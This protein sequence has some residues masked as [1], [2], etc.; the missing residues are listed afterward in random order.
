MRAPLSWLREYVDLPDDVDRRGP[1]RTGSTA[2]GLKLEALERPGADIDGPARRRP[3]AETVDEPQKN[4]KTI[5]W[6]QVDCGPRAR[7]SAASSAART[8][9]RVG[10]LVVVSLPGRGAA[11]RLRDRRP[12]DLR[13]RLRRDD[14][15]HRASSASATTTAASSCS[16]RARRRRRA[17]RPTR[18]PARACATTSSSSRST[19]TAATRL[20]LRGIAREAAIAYDVPFRDPALRDVPAPN[21]DGYPV[22][23]RGRP[24]AARS[25]STRTVTGLRPVG[26]DPAVDAR[27]RV[28]LAGMR[29]ISLAV[30]VTNYV[31]LEL[32]QP[33]HGYDARPAGRPDRRAPGRRE[34]ETLTTLDDVDAHAVR[35][36]PADHRRQRPDRHR[37]RH[38]RRDHRAVGETTATWSS[39]PRTSSRPTIFRTARRHKLPSEASKRFE[40][41]VD[42]LLPAVRRRPGRRT[43]SSS[44]AAARVDRRRHLR[45]QRR[46]DQPSITADVD[47]P[48]RV[49]GM[50]IDADDHRRAPAHASAARST[51]DGDGAL[52]RR[53]RRP[54]GPT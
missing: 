2:L 34:G 54:G 5:N 3:G 37:R 31:M 43:C 20:S 38:G 48:A 4:G 33:I 27:R 35:R 26:A 40:R 6:C 30:D 47:L 50:P 21:D 25:S 46:R 32:G 52:D 39:R 10:D 45:R 24:T 1:A 36:G 14:L 22:P 12:Q 17:R 18:R 42:P 41:G 28:Q 19:P 29:P 13:P 15:L 7:A 8:T 9:S 51:V 23:R 53:C 44:T 16:T 49:T 11:R